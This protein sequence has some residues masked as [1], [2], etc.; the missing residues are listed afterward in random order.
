MRRRL[1][2]FRETKMVSARVELEDYNKFYNLLEYRDHVN[3]QD[4][5]NIAIVNYIS[6]NLYFSGSS[7]VSKQ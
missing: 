1:N 7:L 4:F 3:L 5:V 6:G 2:K